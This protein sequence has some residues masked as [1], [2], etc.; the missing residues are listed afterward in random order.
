MAKKMKTTLLNDIQTF[1]L[2]QQSGSKDKV[3]ILCVVCR[4]RVGYIV[5]G[6]TDVPFRGDMIHCHPGTE[7]WPLPLAHQGAK[8]FV[9]PHAAVEGGDNHL[10]VDLGE[11]LG[12]ELDWFLDDTYQPFQILKSS[13]ECPCGCGGRVRGKN[14]YANGLI[15]YRKHVEALKAEITDDGRTT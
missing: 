14:K 12:D 8:D 9:C 5:P 1:Q 2:Q 11:K 6:E 13:G 10:F 15:C 7:H 3:N 4:D